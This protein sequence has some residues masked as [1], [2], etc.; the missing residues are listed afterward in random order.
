M[1]AL[2][3]LLFVLG[4][5][6]GLELWRWKR[7]EFYKRRNKELDDQLQKEEKE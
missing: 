5:S 7:F 2:K 1:T 4:L 6:I 3:I